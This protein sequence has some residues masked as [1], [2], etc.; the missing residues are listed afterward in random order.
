MRHLIPALTGGLLALALPV[1]S[2]LAWDE[3][4]E[5]RVAASE[6]A[7]LAEFD[8]ALTFGEAAPANGKY[9]WRKDAANSKVDRVVIS[10]SDQLAYAYDGEDLIAV[11]SISSG[12]EGH[13]TPTGIFKVLDKQKSYF[14]KKYDNAPMPYMQRIDDYGVALHA[15]YLPGNPASHGCVRLPK[16]FASKLFAATSVGTEVVIGT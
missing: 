11:S 9:V 7:S 13:D 5:A 4:P 1:Q 6:A 2:A 3:T 10:L 14:S 16:S 15:G 8:L 12:K